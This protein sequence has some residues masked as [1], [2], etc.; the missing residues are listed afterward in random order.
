MARTPRE[1]SA[2][3]MTVTEDGM[4]LLYSDSSLGVIGTVDI[5]D[6]R[7]SEQGRWHRDHGRRKRLNVDR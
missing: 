7:R 5:T 2:E 1:T 4:T 6:R 3:I